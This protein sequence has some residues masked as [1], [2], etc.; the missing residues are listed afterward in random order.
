MQINM[1]HPEGQYTTVHSAD[2]AA[3][4]KQYAVGHCGEIPLHGTGWV[5]SLQRVN[6]QEA[7]PHSP[8]KGQDLN[9]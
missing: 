9:G 2:G 7:A 4:Y 1:L 6:R 5:D 8:Q 3:W